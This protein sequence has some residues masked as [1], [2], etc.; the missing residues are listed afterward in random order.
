MFAQSIPVTTHRELVKIFKDYEAVDI[1]VQALVSQARK[2]DYSNMVVHLSNGSTYSLDVMPTKLIS[3]NYRTIEQMADG[4]QRVTYGTKTLPLRGKLKNVANSS[5]AV[6]LN[7]DFFYASIQIGQNNYYIEPIRYLVDGE[8]SEKYALYNAKDVKASTEKSCAAYEVSKRRNTDILHEAPGDGSRFMMSCY[9]LEYNYASDFSMFQA[10][11]S[12]AGV[13]N[14]VIGV[15]NNVQTNYDNEFTNE[16]EYQLGEHFSSTCSSCDPWTSSTDAGDFLESFSNWG[17][18]G[19]NSAHD[20]AG[21]WTNRDFDGSTIG[22]AWLNGLCNSLRYHALQRWQT[23]NAQSMRCMVSH[24]IGHNFGCNPSSSGDSHDVSGT[25]IMSP[26]VSTTNNWSSI[27]TNTI[28]NAIPNAPCLSACSGG[29]SPPTASFNYNIITNCIPAQVQYFDQSVGATSR[30]WSFPGGTPSTST[31]ANPIVTYNNLGTFGATLTATNSA[32]SNTFTITDVIT[33]EP[34]VVANFTY[35]ISGATVTFTYTGTP[36]ANISWSFG[37]GNTSSVEN[38]VHTYGNDGTYNVTLQTSNSCST[39]TETKTITIIT[40]PIA[41]FSSNITNGCQPLTVE[42]IN[43]SSSNATAFLWTFPGGTPSTSTLANPTVIYNQAGNFDVT[44]KVTNAAGSNTLVSPEYITVYPQPVPGFTVAQSGATVNLTN[45]SSGA[46]SLSYSFGDGSTSTESNPTHTYLS[47]GAFI[48]T[49]TAT[50]NCGST[51][52]SQTVNITQPPIANFNFNTTPICTGQSKTFNSTS[53][54]NPTSYLWEFEGGSPATS[55]EPQPTVTYNNSGTFDVKLTVSNAY[56]QSELIQDNVVIVNTIPS[57]TTMI[58]PDGLTYG[59]AANVTNG[60]FVSWDFGDGSPLDVNSTTTHTYPSQGTYT[61]TAMSENSCGISSSIQTINVVLAPTAAFSSDITTVCSGNTVQFINQSSASATS[62]LWTFEGGSPA[63]STAQNPIVTY[64]NTG[65][66]DV[67]L[68]VTNAAGQGNVAIQDYI[69]VITVPSTGM[70][71]NTVDNVVT[72]TN[73]G[74][75]ASTT[76]WA[77]SG[78]NGFTTSLTGSTVN[79]NAP[80]NGTYT[81]VQTNANSCGNSNTLMQTL[82]VNAYVEASMT[83]PNL[84]CVGIPVTF[85]NASSN[86]TGQSWS[87]D[88]GSPATS[89]ESNP[90]ITYNTAGNYTVQLVASNNLGSATIDRNIEV[91]NAPSSGFTYT[92]S[93]ATAVFTFTGANGTVTWDFGDGTT[94]TENNPTHTYGATGSYT[95]TQTTTNACGSITSTEVLNIVISS[96]QEEKLQPIIFPNPTQG[97][98]DIILNTNN[99]NG[100]VDFLLQDPEGK[101]INEVR[102]PS[103]AKYTLNYENVPAGVYTLKIYYGKDSFI[104]KLIVI[105]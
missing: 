3:P 34:S 66:Y 88:G 35:M 70:S 16:V 18:S 76:N 49:Q 39:D 55:T 82:V 81:I 69:S 92:V 43:Q 65:S 50:N 96:T 54:Y 60:T 68:V 10:Y 56:G 36:G 103:S 27:S 101:I 23:S 74:S 9:L 67:S 85:I 42:F 98:V 78:P 47:N 72:L 87:F 73:T 14:W 80:A 5:V 91:I 40:A 30:S 7:D 62:W 48:I 79:F 37:D 83:V 13:A 11:G 95:V 6:T 97:S 1:N 8:T 64:S 104:A 63:T 31:A 84:I 99:H 94:S 46:T 19:F 86:S 51:T 26:S 52:Q 4:T 24:E 2:G 22:V 90:S 12:T 71:T 20:L 61:V 59:F 93:N 33:T 17:P 15:M 21:V 45:V 89:T 28:N 38:P 105:P 58:S 102:L 29:G 75:G 53:T 41:A 100:K 57:I 77:V 44:L 25:W 32:G